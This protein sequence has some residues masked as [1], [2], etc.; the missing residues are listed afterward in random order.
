MSTAKRFVRVAEPVLDGNEKKY[1]LD[2]LEENWISSKGKYIDRFEK[3]LAE[4]CG[5]RCAVVTNNGT[6]SLHLALLA[7]G[8]DRGDE[9]IMPSLSY[10]ATANVVRYCNA[11]P[12]F[13]DSERRFLSI[14]PNR[15]EAAI[16]PK[17]KAIMT[18]PLY[19]H[20]VD[21][22]PI[23]EIADRHGV[24]VI[25]DS[26]ESLGAEYKG[27]KVGSLAECSSFSFFGNKTITTG[28][29]GAVTTDD[30]SLAE[31]MRFLRGQAV[32]PNRSYWHPEIGYNYR[33]TN[34]AA[35]IGVGQAERLEKHTA[36]RRDIA[37]KYREHL[38]SF[39]DLV[40]LPAEADWALHSYWMYTILIPGQIGCDRDEVMSQ[41]LAAGIETRPVF[42]PI[43]TMPAYRGLAKK[44]FPV[45]E[46]C[47]RRGIN[48][49]THGALTDEDVAFVAENLV[50]IVKNL[51]A[52]PS[53]VRRVA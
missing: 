1:V 44:P 24:S 21:M 41:M 39:Q 20:P 25:E 36:K 51:A 16:T 42:Y 50:S 6:T 37:K 45:A 7:L 19:G 10:V 31:R 32:D 46:D 8:L 2:C 38:W 43:H 18:V 17:T 12:V 28:E 13:V 26:A 4:Y 47:S 33:M 22:D 35:A 34:V 29:G 14:D 53:T 27:R 11:T 49:P 15:I 40:E 52:K 30:E 5:T 48:L 9:V 23:K 3:L